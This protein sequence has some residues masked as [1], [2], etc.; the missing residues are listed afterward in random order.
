MLDLQLHP[1]RTL[2][3]LLAAAHAVS[4]LLIWVMPLILVLQ[5]A[6]S[7]LLATS[8]LFHLRRDGR[9]AAPNSITRLRFSPDCQCAYQTR[10]GAWHEAK[11]LGS[12]L[13]SPWLSVL[14]FKPDGR[15]MPR[16]AVIFPDS[17]DAEGRRKLRVLLRWKY[18]DLAKQ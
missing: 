17:A 1:S 8:F 10:D 16:H 3:M 5:L 18:T 2:G 12:S 9:L 6:A 14:N 7:L 4:L 13:V 11:L 15:R